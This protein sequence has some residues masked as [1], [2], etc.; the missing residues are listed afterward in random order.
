MYSRELPC[1]TQSTYPCSLPQTTL[2]DTPIKRIVPTG[3]ELTD[4][5]VIPLDVIICATGYDTTYHYPFEILGLDGRALNDRW[6]KHAEAYLTVVVDGFPNMFFGLGPNSGL[7]SGSL[8]ILMEKQIEYAV[9][10]TLKLQR[11]RLASIVIK[12]EAM[13][14]WSAYIKVRMLSLPPR[15]CTDVF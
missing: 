3:V 4:G 2:E 6:T 14:D 9:Q 10:A 15:L 8:Q 11:E 7:N 1:R 5:R 12:K 13:A